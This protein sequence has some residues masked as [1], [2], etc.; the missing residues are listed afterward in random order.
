MTIFTSGGIAHGRQTLSG[1]E[2]EVERKGCLMPDDSWGERSWMRDPVDCRLFGPVYNSNSGI[3]AD[4]IRSGSVTAQALRS[5]QRAK[6][7][8]YCGKALRHRKA[9]HVGLR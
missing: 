7:A 4:I 8:F 2:R 3:C 9:H 5:R 1:I 6:A